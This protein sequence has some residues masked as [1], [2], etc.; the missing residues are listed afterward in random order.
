MTVPKPRGLDTAQVC[1]RLGGNKPLDRSTL[2]RAFSETLISP[3]PSTS[4]TEPRDSLKRRLML[5][6]H[7]ESRS[8]MTLS[9]R[10]LDVTVSNAGGNG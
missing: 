10:L 6:S 2:W 5:T 1:A 3:N 8:A 7:G 9:A 4:G